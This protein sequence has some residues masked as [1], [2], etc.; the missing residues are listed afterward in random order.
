MLQVLASANLVHQLVFVS[1]HAGELANVVESVENA[2]GEL[3]S[4]D[5]AETVLDLRVDNELGQA[6]NLAHEMEGI[7]E[8]GLFA[9]FGGECFDRLQIK[10]IYTQRILV[11][12]K[13]LQFRRG[14]T[15]QMQIRQILPVDK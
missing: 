5:I 6:E 8:A 14:H 3:E 4:I 2:I 11:P 1:V 13:T 15:I 10:V 9:F 12:T 7:A